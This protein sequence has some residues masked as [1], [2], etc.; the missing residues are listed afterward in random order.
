M[1]IGE[2]EVLQ[3]SFTGVVRALGLLR[4]DTTPCGQAM[5][6]TEAHALGD[7]HAHGPITQQQL[8]DALRLQKSTISR[9]V[10]RLTEGGLVERTPNPQDR[11]S[12]LIG[13]TPT[14]TRRARRLED[15]RRELFERL[16]AD[17][18]HNE[19]RLVVDGVTRLAQAAHALDE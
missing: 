5:S 3:S 11:R 10:D 8:A 2:A 4:P 1:P 19:R 6:I 14:G 16:L 17:L 9:L 15:A 13:L 7:L 18:A 12:H